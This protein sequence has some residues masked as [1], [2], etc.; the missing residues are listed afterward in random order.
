M[1]GRVLEAE[2][3]PAVLLQVLA[4]PQG[5]SAPSTE[6]DVTL[7]LTLHGVTR[8]MPARVLIEQLGGVM[9]ASGSLQLRQSDFGITPMSVM[10]GAM[11]V[12]DTLELRYRIVARSR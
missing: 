1:L 6:R 7:Q 3:Y 12:A 5:R 2:R 11:T 8:A 4:A 10:G 9:T